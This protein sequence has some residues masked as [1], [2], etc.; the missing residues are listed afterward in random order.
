MPNAPGSSSTALKDNSNTI[1]VS[2]R[3]REEMGC[4]EEIE[5]DSLG[6]VAGCSGASTGLFL[7]EYSKTSPGFGIRV[8]A[9]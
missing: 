1:P 7:Q 8:F 5:F 2:W 9:Q 4:R 3:Y 6:P